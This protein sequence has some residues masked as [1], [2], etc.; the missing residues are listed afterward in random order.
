[1]P[2]A[3]S[4][5]PINLFGLLQRSL[6][7][8]NWVICLVLCLSN[9]ALAEEFKAGNEPNG[10]NMDDSLSF[11]GSSPTFDLDQLGKWAVSPILSGMGF[12]QSNPL[13]GAVDF[14]NAQLLIHKNEG[15]FQFFVQ[16][17]LYSVPVLG[18]TYVRSISESVGTYGYIPQAYATY[19]HDE[20]WSIS[21]GKLPSMGGYES[22]FTYQNLNIQRGLLWDQTSSVSYGAQLNYSKDDLSI[23]FTWN[24]GYY[25]NKMNWLGT[26]IAY[27]LNAKQNIGFSWV[28]STSGNSQDTPTTPLLQN[29]SQIINLLYSYSGDRWY[30]APYLQMT[31]IP[32][33]TAIGITSEYKT[34]GA[35]LLANYRFSGFES[36]GYQHPKI[37]LP[38]RL[39]YI[40]EKGGS[41]GSSQTILYGPNSS[42]ASLTV[43]PTIQ[44][45]KYFARLEGSIVRID[46]PQLGLGF[47]QADSKKSQF[48]LMLEAGILY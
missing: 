48:R 16:T 19:I 22:T 40:A 45:D 25:S 20:Q 12:R 7:L 8:P 30:F 29:N 3:Y 17:G 36:E 44:Y 13:A 43:T 6:A 37:S 1:M 28:G 4:L 39:E 38:V 35:V 10:F 5:D 42:A 9:V 31:I 23:A 21:A 27:Q 32:A 2:S 34:Y 14:S 33:N 46:N 47:G 24:D 18:K 15:S 41:V 11:T 26:A